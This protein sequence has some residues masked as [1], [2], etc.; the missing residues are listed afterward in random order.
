[1]DGEVALWYVRS[2][3]TSSDFDR[4]RRAQEVLIGF[5]K[6][7]MSLDG[8]SKAPEIYNQFI[9]SVETDLT[10]NDILS[11]INIA[12]A[13]FADNSLIER[14]EIGPEHVTPH[15]IPSTGASVQ[16]PNYDAIWQ[17]IQKAVY[18]P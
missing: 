6:K 14:Y 11:F 2:R 4:T 10:L 12:P 15:I 18:T 9:S 5:F 13:I 17:V 1:M 3:Y 16:L 8:I 7:L